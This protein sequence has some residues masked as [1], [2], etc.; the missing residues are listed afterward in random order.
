MHQT[1]MID[2][3]YITLG[4]L[5]QEAGVIDSGGMAKLFLSDFEVFVNDEPDQRRGRKL[6]H[7]DEIDIEEVG[8]ISISSNRS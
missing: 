1:I 5:L 3:E 8:K 2:T 7:G 6:Y 4:Q